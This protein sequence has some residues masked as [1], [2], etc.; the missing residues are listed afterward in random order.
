MRNEPITLEEYCLEHSLDI[1]TQA[2][3]S[4]CTHSKEPFELVS[5]DDDPEVYVCGHCTMDDHRR[6][7]ALA[8]VDA[9]EEWNSIRVLRNKK[10]EDHA[11]TVAPHSPLS[12]Q[13]KDNF[14]QYLRLLHR[15][16]VDYSSP[17]EVIWPALPE[18]EYSTDDGGVDE[19]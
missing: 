17:S 8:P 12:E 5:W 13:S 18:Y 3:C 6:S 1:P 9:N 16:T 10:L 7:E 14:M 2:A 19:G 4:Q 15:I 11:W